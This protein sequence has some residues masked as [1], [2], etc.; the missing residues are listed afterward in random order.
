MCV[1]IAKDRDVDVI[2][3]KGRTLAW[4]RKIKCSIPVVPT[5]SYGEESIVALWEIRQKWDIE[6]KEKAE[7]RIPKVALLS[8][9]P[10]N[11]DEALYSAIF[12][13]NVKNVVIPSLDYNKSE[14]FLLE[15][16]SKG[17]DYIVCGKNFK[18]AVER[19]DI[20]AF[21]LIR[22][23][24]PQMI[25]RDLDL[26]KLVAQ[27]I[28]DYKHSFEEMQ[29]IINYAFEAV[30]TVN[31]E[32][33][34]SVCN[35]IAAKVFSCDA[36]EAVGKQIWEV[37]PA[38]PEDITEQVLKNGEKYYGYVLEYG[39]QVF[40]MNVTPLKKK[41]NVTGAVFHFT[42]FQ[43]IEKL[44]ATVKREYY[45]KGYAARYTFEDIVG[46]SGEM[47]ESKRLAEQ[48]AKYNSNVLIVGETGT[49]KEVFAQSIHNASLRKKEPFVA[50]NC[51]AIPVNLL[52]SELFG[53]VDGAFTGA[54]KKGKRGL[55][56]IADHGTLFLDEVSEMDLT[57]QVQLL[58]VLEERVIRRVGDDKEI[59]VD[60][61]VIAA[62]N[63]NLLELIEQGKFREDLYYRLNVLTLYVPPLREREDDILLLTRK[64]VGEF[65]KALRK[66]VRISEEAEKRI[67][68]YEWRGNV[69]QLKNFCERLVIV[70]DE[71]ELSTAF[72]ERQLSDVY[73][74]KL[75][76]QRREAI[77]KRMEGES[78]VPQGI[79]PLNE[80]ESIIRALNE[81][82]G[83]RLQAAELL[84]I[85]KTSL[86]RKMKNYGITEQY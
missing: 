50:V 41:Q 14:L 24:L 38:L 25:W 23:S 65:G 32:G 11:I 33:K 83:N 12:H 72:V 68:Q 27:G 80:K 73:M 86:W 39:S 31:Q 2:I 3:A 37:V 20:E 16:K 79:L 26:A 17:Y 78:K 21:Y 13:M 4:L 28:S 54:L 58:R 29:T 51:G 62:S 34:I 6:R 45:S 69:R 84:G 77:P 40:V 60:I 22:P 55:I 46:A 82:G 53:Y 44:E 52:E 19:V 70:A 67:C 85:S 5:T 48:F 35:Q 10:L 71:P 43:N 1:A 61:R 15:L 9:L 75:S 81:T 8:H 47:E 59:P 56:E 49:G 7:E 30:I 42:E 76:K 74:L 18:D 63:K 66:N 36:E 64:F 57:G